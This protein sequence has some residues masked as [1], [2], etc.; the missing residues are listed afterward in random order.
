[1]NEKPAD[2]EIRLNS[3]TRL[4]KVSLT[5]AMVKKAIMTYSYNS[6][7]PQMSHTVKSSMFG[8]D[9]IIDGK[10]EEVYSLSEDETNNWLTYKDSPNFIKAFIAVI[11]EVFPKMQ[12]LKNYMEGIVKMCFDLAI[13]VP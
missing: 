8:H 2:T 7:F 11:Q 6:S 5:R 9:M 10:I 4:S 13:A 3:F 12:H 1:M